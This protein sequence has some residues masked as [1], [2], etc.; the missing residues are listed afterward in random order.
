MT[1]SQ[2]NSFEKAIFLLAYVRAKER[3]S[4]EFCMTGEGIDL[5][6]YGFGHIGSI[7]GT[8]VMEIPEWH[9]A[10]IKADFEDRV[11]FAIRMLMSMPEA[12]TPKTSELY[13][14]ALE[15]PNIDDLM[16]GD[17]SDLSGLQLQ[18]W[19]RDELSTKAGWTEDESK[20]LNSLHL[21]DGVFAFGDHAHTIIKVS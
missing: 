19:S 5:E 3:R 21:F 13:V 4:P 1:N 18:F 20:T 9:N 11:D 2:S 6:N 12:T 16:L 15:E 10:L 7:L 14:V 17:L 8:D